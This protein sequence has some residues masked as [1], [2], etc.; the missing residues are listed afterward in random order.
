MSTPPRNVPAL[1]ATADAYLFDLDGVITPTALVHRGAWS[2]LFTEFFAR[3]GVERQYTEDDYF[4]FVD[5]RPRYDGVRDVLASRGIVLPEGDIDDPSDAETVTGLG[6]RKNE[7]FTAELEESGIEAYPGSIAF[8]DAT[9]GHRV[10]L[11]SSSRN[12]IPVLERAGIRD[13]FEVVV[14]GTA[15]TEHDLAGKPAPDT[16]RYAAALFG[17]PPERCVVFEDAPSGVEAG[18][19]GGFGLV[20][21]VDRGAGAATLRASGADL[22]V[23][24]LAELIP[25]IGGH[26]A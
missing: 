8:L 23:S 12:A 11:V 6:N 17:L 13:R 7:L 15:V 19:A 5:G 14:D 20:V 21:G 18:A 22:V 24:D 3:H 10:A 1:L 2:R 26:R 4:A 25:S 16:F 9:P